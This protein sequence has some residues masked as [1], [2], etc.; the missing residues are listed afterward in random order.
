MATVDTHVASH[1]HVEEH[2]HHEQLSFLRKY[3]FSEDHKTI[4][5]QYM[6]SGIF[7]AILGA[8]LSV[9]FRLQLGFPDM[10]MEWLRP[11]LGNWITEQ[12]KLDQE[13]YLALV[14]MHGTIMVFFVL[15]AGLSGTFSNFLIPLQIGA[16]DMAS[17]FL[18]MLSY[19]FFFLSSVLMFASL[20]L[21]T[22]PASGGWVVYPPLSALPQAIDGSKMGMTLWLMS[23]A[24]FIVS[25]LLGGINYITTVINLRTRGMSFSKLPLPIWAFFL[26]AVLGLISFPVL[27]SAALLLIF[28]R[29]FGTSFYLSE[30]YIGGEALPNVGGSPILYQHLFWFLG[31]PEVYIVLLPALGITSEVIATN[32]RKPIFGYRAMI[33][34]MIGIAF[35]AFIVWAHHMFV[36]G[37]NPFLG[38]IFMF[39]TLIIAVPS[40]VK[41]FNYITTLWKGNIVFTP[42]M[43]FSIGLVSFFISGGVTGIIL[44]NSALDI[45]LHDTYFVVAHFH[46]VMG[47]ASAFGLLAGIYHWFPKMFGRM[48]NAK[49][50]YIHFWLTFIGIY[51][52]FFPMHYIG[53]AGFPRRYYSFTSY[54]AFKTFGDLNTFVSIAAIFTFSAQWIF[55]WNFFYSLFKGKKAPLNPWRSNT[56]EWTTPIV[57]GHGNWPGEIPAVYRWPYDYSKPGAKEDFIPQTVPF[58]QTPESNLPHETAQIALEKEIEAQNFNDQFKQPH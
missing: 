37:M 24:L 31:H 30:I 23:M 43:L 9:L 1:A 42:A 50:G 26:T 28:D 7:W 52:V 16:R 53:I 6:I 49:L 47:A 25:Q 36:T 22:G 40:A 4:A 17:G 32:S 51:L 27:L 10:N 41:A 12:G 14:T 48:M 18:N 57:P 33:A 34:S 21:E 29:S 38:S 55:I 5:K 8:S 13:F 35:L 44:G 20:F 2:D 46:L 58:S 54:D 11:V 56:L 15:T 19:W 39:L 45:Q 3:I